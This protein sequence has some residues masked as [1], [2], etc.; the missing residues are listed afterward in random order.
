MSV[1]F[2]GPMDLRIV[3][4]IQVHDMEL[5]QLNRKVKWQCKHSNFLIV[6]LELQC[7][8]AGPWNYADAQALRSCKGSFPQNADVKIAFQY[9][10]FQRM[11]E[12]FLTATSL[13]GC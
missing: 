6:H 4:E 10:R 1:I 13:G 3:G 7:D 2:E 9:L 5:Y 8:S 12:P 11:G